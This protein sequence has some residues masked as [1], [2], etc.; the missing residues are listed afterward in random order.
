MEPVI[1]VPA[2][3]GVATSIPAR[4]HSSPPAT[5][6][7]ACALVAALGVLGVAD[8]RAQS[9]DLLPGRVPAP[10]ASRSNLFQPASLIT[11]Q[12]APA[13]PVHVKAQTAVFIVGVAA[14]AAVGAF[15]SK[16]AP[17]SCRWCDLH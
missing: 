1:G 9:F 10:Q 13:E 11:A 6:V 5:L 3:G 14:L 12:E 8:A 15:Q 7:F 17:S 4:C 2:G 16:L